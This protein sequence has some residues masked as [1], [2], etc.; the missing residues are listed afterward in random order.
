[1]NSDEEMLDTKHKPPQNNKNN[2]KSSK[3]IHLALLL[4]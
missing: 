3:D 2:K 1:M 4:E